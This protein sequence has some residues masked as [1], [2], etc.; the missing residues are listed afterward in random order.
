M[1]SVIFFQLMTYKMF[2]MLNRHFFRS[3]LPLEHLKIGIGSMSPEGAL[4]LAHHWKD[5]DGIAHHIDLDPAA[6]F[7]L[8]AGKMNPFWYAYTSVLLHEMVHYA[9]DL[10]DVATVDANGWHNEVFRDEAQAHG[11]ACQLDN[12]GWNVTWLD[13]D[14][15]SPRMRSS[16]E[17]KRI[18]ELYGQ[19][20]PYNKVILARPGSILI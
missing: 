1:N 18:I 2:C 13:D 11:L 3:S 9:C 4:A 8:G 12:R 7:E 14:P 6:V 5:D 15:L 19:T 20:E 17:L 10:R 16:Q